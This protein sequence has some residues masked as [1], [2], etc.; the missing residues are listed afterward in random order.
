MTWNWWQGEMTNQI[1]DSNHDT[2]SKPQW[3]KLINTF[4]CICISSVVSRQKS[5]TMLCTL[6]SPKQTNKKKHKKC[7]I[8]HCFDIPRVGQEGAK[9][10][11]EASRP[12]PSW[13]PLSHLLVSTYG[14]LWCKNPFDI[15]QVCERFKKS[16]LSSRFNIKLIQLELTVLTNKSA[17]DFFLFV[18]L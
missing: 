11:G 6:N 14:R 1:T 2:S 4:F 5:K 3:F 17:N 15:K 7:E 16:S 18:C 8:S 12:K 9:S 10:A 13:G